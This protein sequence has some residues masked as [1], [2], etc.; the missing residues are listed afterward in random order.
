MKNKQIEKITT[1]LLSVSIILII[2]GAF[3]K[4]MHNSNGNLVIWIGFITQF[5][6][7][8]FEIKRLKEIIKSS[9]KDNSMID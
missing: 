6:F 7:S 2:S 5:I 9:E 1:I 3:L 8:S 4:I